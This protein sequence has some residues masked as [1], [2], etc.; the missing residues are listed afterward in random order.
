MLFWP[1]LDNQRY[2]PRVS[3]PLSDELPVTYK[4]FPGPMLREMP[5]FPN[6]Y[7]TNPP[8]PA[9]RTITEDTVVYKGKHTSFSER[10]AQYNSTSSFA[11]DNAPYWRYTGYWR[12]PP[13]FLQVDATNPSLL[14]MPI[15]IDAAG[16]INFTIG[17]R[18]SGLFLFQRNDGDQ[19]SNED[20]EFGGGAD[21]PEL[22]NWVRYRPIY[23]ITTKEDFSYADSGM[24]LSFG[25]WSQRV[26]TSPSRFNIAPPCWNLQFKHEEEGNA[27]FWPLVF[28]P[29]TYFNYFEGK[30]KEL[31]KWYATNTPTY[32]DPTVELA[33]VSYALTGE[34]FQTNSTTAAGES[35]GH[36]SPYKE[37]DYVLGFMN[38]ENGGIPNIYGNFI[39]HSPNTATFFPHIKVKP[40]TL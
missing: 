9:D 39:S 36:L 38:Y 15:N 12:T 16:T 29:V 7:T 17:A 28:L 14:S 20:D 5:Y 19:Y 27:N 8:T 1:G 30:T 4:T 35:H 32:R 31:R 26:F 24:S 2:G 21:N 3:V 25:Y 37:I 33:G 13:K 10:Y 18:N 22:A 23:N 6:R 40:I 34:G 11:F